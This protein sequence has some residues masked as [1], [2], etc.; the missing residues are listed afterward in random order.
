MTGTRK[1]AGG[2]SSPTMGT[3]LLI[4]AMAASCSKSRFDYS[5]MKQDLLRSHSQSN[6]QKTA[7]SGI[8]GQ[9]AHGA[10]FWDTWIVT[11]S[12]LDQPYHLV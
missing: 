10:L 1:A 8:S 7:D 4:P 3:V 9:W 12:W 6:N 5:S 2:A 11:W